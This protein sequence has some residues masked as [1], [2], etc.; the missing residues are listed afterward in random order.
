MST[1][2]ILAPTP[3]GMT[4]DQ[5][6]RAHRAM[7]E[8]MMLI[9]RGLAVDHPAVR[10]AAEIVGSAVAPDPA[11]FALADPDPVPDRSAA[12]GE[13]ERPPAAHGRNQEAYA[14]YLKTILSTQPS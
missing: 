3:E 14:R 11:E 1:I 12:M 5:Y 7:L 10:N 8:Q 13:P 9:A 6:R 2:A 4:P